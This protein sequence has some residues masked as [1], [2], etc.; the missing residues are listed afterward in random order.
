MSKISDKTDEFLLNYSHLFWDR[1]YS[2][3]IIP[4]I[5]L[6]QGRIFAIIEQVEKCVP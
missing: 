2:N 1:L 6:Q 3:T 5:T 4:E